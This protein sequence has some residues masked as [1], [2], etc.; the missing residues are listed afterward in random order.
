MLLTPLC[1]FATDVPE[2]K[3]TTTPVA[4]AKA[5]DSAAAAAAAPAEEDAEPGECCVIPRG[6]LCDGLVWAF[7]SSRSGWACL[8]CVRRVSLV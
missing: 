5:G 1:V 3:P 7:F 8:S 6:L 4:E 2:V